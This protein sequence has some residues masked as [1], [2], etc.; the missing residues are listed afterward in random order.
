MRR[1]YIVLLA[2][3]LADSVKAQDYSSPEVVQNQEVFLQLDRTFYLSGDKL[4]FSLFN[5]DSK[6]GRLI[7]GKRF[8]KLTLLNPSG[9]VIMSE[10]LKVQDGRSAGQFILPLSIP[11][12]EYVLHLGYMGELPD[13]YLFR[14]KLS[15][16]N[17]AEVL[18]KASGAQVHFAVNSK[19]ITP[20]SQNIS[21]SL[22]KSGFNS[23]E[24]VVVNLSGQ[25]N[26]Q[27][28]IAVRP[29]GETDVLIE[30]GSG[31]SKFNLRSNKALDFKAPQD[32]A[33]LLFDLLPKTD[34]QP[35]SRPY[36]FI[37]EDHRIKGFYKVSNGVYSFDLTDLSG[38]EKTFYFNQFSNKPYVPPTAEWDYEKDRY[39]DH[40]VPYFEGEMD[41]EWEEPD[42]DYTQAI[43]DISFQ[44]PSID[45]QVMQYALQK[46]VLES[47]VASGAYDDVPVQIQEPQTDLMMAPSLFY[48]KASDYEQMN[49]IAEYL[50]EIVTGVRA[51]DRDNKRDIRV[52]FVGGMYHDSPLFLVDGIPTRD[53]EKILNIPIEDVHGAGVIKDHKAK[54]QYK[55]N[56]E[57]RPYGVFAGSGIVVIHLKP[58][59]SNPFR[60]DY[61]G[62][63]KK[64]VY[65]AQDIYPNA[66]YQSSGSFNSIPDFRRTLYW[67]P[68]FELSETSNTVSF[69][70]SDV[71]GQYEVIVQ[72]ISAEGEQIFARQTFSVSA[73]IE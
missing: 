26:A 44:S 33:W 34:L 30:K 4:W 18:E 63:L 65:I 25:T 13:Q 52:M 16:F 28:S 27:L 20:V 43:G 54:A 56:D 45:D 57:A 32:H 68:T 23:K 5:Y 22:S 12:N 69:Y 53:V 2:I 15:I 66:D 70:T 9:E 42:L 31:Y 36:A 6:S 14:K 60:V 11:S 67:N 19:E 59:A 55:F 51:W 64:R 1:I 73:G 61:D 10:N 47:V 29:V 35:D 24:Q 62:M 46:S 40:L 39:K 41:F 38:G 3:A 21:V 48:K 7:K 8:M 37:P 58:G 17:R 71:P 50:Y 72:G 49:N